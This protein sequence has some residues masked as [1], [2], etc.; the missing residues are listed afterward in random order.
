[1]PSFL[2]YDNNLSLHIFHPKI[3]WML[4][5]LSIHPLEEET[6]T[7][8]KGARTRTLRGPV[9]GPG[10]HRSPGLRPG[11]PQPRGEK[12]GTTNTL[13]T[14]R[15][16]LVPHGHT[17]APSPHQQ[18]DH[19]RVRTKFLH[20]TPATQQLTVLKRLPTNTNSYQ[21]RAPQVLSMR[22]LCGLK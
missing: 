19:L 20:Q 17:W 18:Q 6:H 1:M 5:I 7:V 8:R 9:P 3:L 2:L 14:P 22:I 10:S 11:V 12:P 15:Q 21:Q 4:K 13:H 16:R